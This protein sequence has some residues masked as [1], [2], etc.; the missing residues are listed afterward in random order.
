MAISQKSLV[1]SVPTQLLI[2]LVPRDERALNQQEWQRRVSPLM[3]NSHSPL[4]STSTKRAAAKA[5]K[6]SPRVPFAPRVLSRDFQATPW[7]R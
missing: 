1:D 2:G 7:A 4:V 5:L 3:A 6:V